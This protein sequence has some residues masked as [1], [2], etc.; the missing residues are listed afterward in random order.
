MKYGHDKWKGCDEPIL[1][2]HLQIKTHY[3]CGQWFHTFD[4]TFAGSSSPFFYHKQNW[5][6]LLDCTAGEL[7][8][9]LMDCQKKSLTPSEIGNGKELSPVTRRIVTLHFFGCWKTAA[10]GG[11]LIESASKFDS[12]H[13]NVFSLATRDNCQTALNYCWG[14]ESFHQRSC[15]SACSSHRDGELIHAVP[16]TMISILYQHAHDILYFQKIQKVK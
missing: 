7:R 3:L 15:R 2:A 9:I 16:W 11:V 5:K 1:S 14:T 6:G 12:M 13:C 10:D 4:T 8:H